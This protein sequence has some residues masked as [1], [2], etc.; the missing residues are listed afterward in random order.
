MHSLA[1][2]GSCP[3][4]IGILSSSPAFHSSIS[5]SLADGSLASFWNSCWNRVSTLKFRFP[6]IYE[7]ASCKH[8][9]VRKWVARFAGSPNLGLAP[10]LAGQIQTEIGQLRGELENVRLCAGRDGVILKWASNGCFSVSSAYSFLI[11]DG[12]EDRHSRVFWKLK[13]PLSIK[14][15]LWL[16]ARDRLLTA[17]QLLRRGWLGHSVCVLCM[18]NEERIEHI[19]FDCPFASS[20]WA[21]VLSGHPPSAQRLLLGSGDLITRWKRARAALTP[22]LQLSVDVGIA[23]GC[24]ELWKERNRRIFDDASNSVV[25]CGH[26]AASTIRLWSTALDCS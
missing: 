24:W 9:S 22:N 1:P 19:L 13:I 23:A 16:A 11:F 8:L 18:A 25:A 21:L 5:F 6:G 17:V 3:L 15:F 7:S 10:P 14:I 2:A 26:T 12:V 4:W 20:F